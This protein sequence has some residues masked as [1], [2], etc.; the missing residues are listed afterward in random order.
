MV[1]WAYEKNVNPDAYQYVE[2]LRK[3]LYSEDFQKANELGRKMQ[4][5][6]TDF[7]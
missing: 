4:G 5:Y 2:P 6:F 7:D 3:A 1:W